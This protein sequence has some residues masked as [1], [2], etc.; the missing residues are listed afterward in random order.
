MDRLNYAN[1][2]CKDCVRP[3]CFV[4]GCN[5]SATTYVRIELNDRVDGLIRVCDSCL[6]NIQSNQQTLCVTKRRSC[7]DGLKKMSSNVRRGWYTAGQLDCSWDGSSEWCVCGHHV[8]DHKQLKCL[9]TKTRPKSWVLQI[10][11]GEII[12]DCSGGRNEKCF[13]KFFKPYCH[14][15]ST[16]QPGSS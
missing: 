2:E 8:T 7:S 5:N 4:V 12:S 3:I 13:C 6:P 9:T 10:W 16:K 14:R 11:D 15:V 1:V